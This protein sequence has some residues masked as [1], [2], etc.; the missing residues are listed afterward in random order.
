VIPLRERWNKPAR[1][2]TL[3]NR[4]HT[5]ARRPSRNGADSK[6]PTHIEACSQCA[7]PASQVGFHT[8]GCPVCAAL[9][10]IQ[11][12]SSP[13]HRATSARTAGG[14]NT[15]SVFCVL[16]FQENGIWDASQVLWQ[17]SLT[18]THADCNTDFALDPSLASPA[19]LPHIFF[20]DRADTPPQ[21]PLST[22]NS[23]PLPH[24]LTSDTEQDALCLMDA[25]SALSSK[26]TRNEIAAT[27][28]RHI[29]KI[30]HSDYAALLLKDPE[31]HLCVTGANPREPHPGPVDTPFFCSAA[32]AITSGKTVIERLP[33]KLVLAVPL[34]GI[35]DQEGALQI[36]FSLQDPN[37]DKRIVELCEAISTQT[38]I[39]LTRALRAEE[40]E[41]LAHTDPLT[42]LPNR[43]KLL[44]QLE[45]AATQATRDQTSLSVAM[46]DMDHFKQY[47]D[48][49]GHDAGD[50]LL[51]SF[52]SFLI[53]E[54]TASPVPGCFG[55]VA[56]RY[57]GE[58]F[59][60]CFPTTKEIATTA[61]QHLLNKWR[62]NPTRTTFSAGVSAHRQG[63]S[64]R[65]LVKRADISLYEAKKVRNQVTTA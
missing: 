16:V 10:A 60:L 47:N 7:N 39:A 21:N 28:C 12:A 38:G 27:A 26:L 11:N 20:P 61:T 23:P 31:G 14:K 63:E 4:A 22:S 30:S 5:R 33:N 19:H 2:R 34:R 53:Q 45:E 49:Y 9:H 6:D 37:P 41:R 42:G 18:N 48:I 58:E 50:Q 44:V 62:E 52:G 57:G 55:A 25:I 54:L 56:G 13:V 1:L 36:G 3:L 51:C 32:H 29:R 65:E 46:I 35:S 8:Q 43:R 24:R 17:N 40:F 15:T 59:L 64:M